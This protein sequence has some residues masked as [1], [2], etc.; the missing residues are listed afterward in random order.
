MVL[1]IVMGEIGIAQ[2]EASHLCSVAQ[3]ARR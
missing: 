3:A 2:R 1:V